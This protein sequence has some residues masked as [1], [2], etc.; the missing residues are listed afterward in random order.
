[1]SR[2]AYASQE[3]VRES[4]ER[5]GFAPPE[6]IGGESAEE[7]AGL[8]G[9]QGFVTRHPSLKLTVL[10]FRGT[11]PDKFEDLIADADTLQRAWPNS[12]GCVA[13]AGFARCWV[14]V[15]DRVTSLLAQ[16]E[17]TLLMTGHSLGAALATLAATVVK[18]TKLITF[19]SP[20]VGNE[21]LCGL[22]AGVEVRRF[23]NCCDLIARIP[24]ERFDQKCV[25]DLLTALVHPGL[26]NIL[27][28]A[29][30]QG[31]AEA[32]ALGFHELHLEPF[33]HLTP[34]QYADRN[35]TLLGDVDDE[36]RLRDQEAARRAY[37]HPSHH[38]SFR[39][40]VV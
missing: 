13:H 24:P 6:P 27:E 19:G 29:L 4:L 11:E 26:H 5:I 9:T 32:V 21:N 7:R 25:G 30:L 14:P 2:L 8:R 3:V 22:L 10:T 23:V 17:D 35:G 37:E 33:E 16:H 20:R 1:M 38:E 36:V 31:A 34:A 28:R 18:P 12:P 39:Q 15:N 40:L